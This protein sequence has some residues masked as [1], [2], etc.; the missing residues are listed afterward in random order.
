MPNITLKAPDTNNLRRSGSFAIASGSSPALQE[1]S[2]QAYSVGA[3]MKGDL[4]VDSWER[5]ISNRLA[6]ENKNYE[7]NG[8]LVP[9]AGL[10]SK[11]DLSAQSGN[12]TGGYLI[13]NEVVD[14]IVPAL[15]NKSA[16]LGAGAVILPSLSG[17]NLSIPRVAIP[18]VAGSGE[19]TDVAIGTIAFEQF[20]LSAN[21]YHA[22][23]LVSN[24]LLVQAQDPAIDAYLKDMLLTTVS[25]LVDKMCM[26]CLRSCGQV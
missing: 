20:K 25:K 16:I 17:S 19:T 7:V 11:P 13:E 22:K 12:S 21:H 5:Q 6:D 15:R 10:A 2:R 14:F 3:V 23:L 18:G 24:Q 9:L 8:C 1:L 4:R 26:G